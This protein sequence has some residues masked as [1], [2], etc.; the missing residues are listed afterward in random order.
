MEIKPGKQTSEL[1]FNVAAAVIGLLT[2]YGYLSQDEANAW[3]ALALAGIPA[4]L[5]VVYTWSRTRVKQQA[6]GNGTEVE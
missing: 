1:W 6:N 5:A 2:A 4:V 3:L